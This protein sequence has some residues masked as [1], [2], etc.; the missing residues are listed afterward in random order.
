[1][2]TVSHHGTL[3][4]G[5]LSDWEFSHTQV[6]NLGEGQVEFEVMREVEW[7]KKQRA[8]TCLRNRPFKKRKEKKK[9][10]KASVPNNKDNLIPPLK[11]KPL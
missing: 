1:M 11:Q 8:T 4:P 2:F 6:F 7:A 9:K 3:F 10:L 5:K